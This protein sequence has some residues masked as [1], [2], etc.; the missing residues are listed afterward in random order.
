MDT[1]RL[2]RIH[3]RVQRT[4]LSVRDKT[5]TAVGCH[6]PAAWC[7]AHHDVPWAAGGRTSVRGGRLRITKNSRRRYSGAAGGHRP[8]ERLTDAGLVC[9]DNA[10]VRA[11]PRAP[12]VP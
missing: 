3:N 6:R 7:H 8:H 9:D 5:C 1:G 10:A 4:A 11:A 12:T 2:T